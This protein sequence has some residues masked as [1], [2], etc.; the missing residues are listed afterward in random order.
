[1]KEISL[2]KNPFQYITEYIFTEAKEL[3]TPED[4]KSYICEMEEIIRVAAEE[5]SLMA[6]EL[7]HAEQAL[8]K[9]GEQND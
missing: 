1:M 2:Y 9:Y 6:W 8:E 5:M 4:M 7:M 3:Q